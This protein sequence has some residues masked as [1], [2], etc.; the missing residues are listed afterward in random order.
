MENICN[1]YYDESFNVV[2]DGG[3]WSKEERLAL[4]DL[5]MDSEAKFEL[6]Y[7]K[8][9]L[10]ELKKRV[11]KRNES[12]ANEFQ[13]R[14]EDLEIAYSKYQEPSELDEKFTLC[15]N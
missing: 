1:T 14:V 2:M 5:A 7:T 11:A 15:M 3:Y 12:L 10:E 4:R 9:A 6:F 8:T 13:M